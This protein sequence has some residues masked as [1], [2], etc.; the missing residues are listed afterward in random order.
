MS[1]RNISKIEL[2]KLGVIPSAPNLANTVL[3]EVEFCPTMKVCSKCKI[4]KNILSF[5][6]NSQLKSGLNSS[7]K[8]CQK[9]AFK[10][11]RNKNLERERERYI[12]YRKSNPEICKNASKN[13]YINNIDKIN[14]YRKIPK[15][16]ARINEIARKSRLKN[17]QKAKSRL[18]IWRLNNKQNII[19]YS[20]RKVEELNNQYVI[21][22]MVRD[23]F[24]KQQLINNPELIEIK[25]LIIKTKRLCKTSQI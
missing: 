4:N 11:Y 2:Q 12:S 1:S 10:E 21:C 22:N 6:K 15:V 8:D 3:A 16:R 5:C 25:K 14:E 7:C 24:T 13:Y 17:L 23:G 20:K 9:L 18:S 19:E